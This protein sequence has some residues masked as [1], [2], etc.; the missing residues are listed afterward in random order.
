MPCSPR[1][2]HKPGRYAVKTEGYDMHFTARISDPA[3][4]SALQ[5]SETLSRTLRE[6]CTIA[7]AYRA[8]GNAPPQT[9]T[10]KE[11]V[12]QLTG[13]ATNINQVVSGVHQR[14]ENA[15]VIGA[16]AAVK[17]ELEELRAVEVEI[18]RYVEYWRKHIQ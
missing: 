4:V 1:T 7:L 12:R 8:N 3:I 15:E 14:G 6:L 11:A 5:N 17:S 13:L 10:L 18:R 16:L 9:E 2:G